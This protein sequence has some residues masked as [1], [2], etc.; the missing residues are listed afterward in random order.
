MIDCICRIISDGYHLT[1]LLKDAC[2]MI[3]YAAIEANE[4]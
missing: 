1:V 2:C 3:C 4:I